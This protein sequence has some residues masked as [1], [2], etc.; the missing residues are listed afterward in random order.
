MS[1]EAWENEGGASYPAAPKDM[2]SRR[3]WMEWRN[4]ELQKGVTPPASGTYGAQPKK[5]KA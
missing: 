1:E 2:L 3:A 5:P 4:R